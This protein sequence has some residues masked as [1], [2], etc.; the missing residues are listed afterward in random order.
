MRTT[1]AACWTSARASREPACRN[2]RPARF[3]PVS[4]WCG[5]LRCARNRRIGRGKRTSGRS[6]SHGWTCRSQ[7]SASSACQPFSN[8][9]PEQPV[10]V[11]NA[12]AVRG[13]AHGRHGVEEAGGETAEP[14]VAERGIRL[15]GEESAVVDAQFLDDGPQPFVE[16]QVGDGILEQPADEEFHRE[17]VD[18]LAILGIDPSGGLEPG[19]NH[20]IANRP[21]HRQPPV[22]QR[23]SGR[24]LPGCVA[25]VVLDGLAQRRV[26]RRRA[27]I[28]IAR[29][30]WHRSPQVR[31]S[32]ASRPRRSRIPAISAAAAMTGA[33]ASCGSRPSSPDPFS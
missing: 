14:A 27:R 2:R 6:N 24:R 17:V 9:L 4:R 19:R 31:T 12:V 26:V 20:E 29:F 28:V 23:R 30:G 33:R 5:H 25:Q 18:P 3:P 15:V 22:R 8:G 13:E 1:G 21:R 7:S 10:V 32:G 11:A 16:P